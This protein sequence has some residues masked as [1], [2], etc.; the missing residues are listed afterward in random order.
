MNVIILTTRISGTDGVSLEA[1]RW[2]EILQS[3]GHKVTFV[4]GKLDRPG[5]LIPELHFQWPNVVELHDEV[6]W[7]KGDYKKVEAEIFTVAGVIEGKLREILNR[8][9]RVDLLIIANALSIP[10]H[11]PLAV[12]LTRV[13]EELK[14]PVIARHHDFWW[15][16]KRFLKSTMFP[17]FQR[18]FPPNLP[19]LHHVVI[20][21]IAKK[22]LY[23][24]YRINSHVIW[25][26]FDFKSRQLQ[27]LDSFNKNWRSDF[28]IKDDDIVFLQATRIVPRK[29]IELAI[30]LVE[31]LGNKSAV[32]VIAGY[33]GD[34]GKEY[35]DYLRKIVRK[36]VV[37]VR[38]IGNHINSQRKMKT[39]KVYTLWDCFVHCDFVTY[40]TKVEGFG[41]QF[42][43]TI[44]FKKP[45]ILTPYSVFKSDIEPLGFETILMPDKV[46]KNVISE[47]NSLIEDK[48]RRRKMVEKNF[49]L[50]KKHFSYEATAKKL[51]KIFKEMNLE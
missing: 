9:K 28:K 39:Q 33:S 45:I 47:V 12:A 40:P 15:E 35:E 38:F 21:S 6:I 29:R 43:E 42:I 36:K 3:M 44:Y 25:D 16:R 4:A 20:N 17:F 18:W 31:K 14:I 1:V 10:M 30:E 11:F 51:Q 19:H 23:K 32:L 46:T 34:E 50:G 27:K 48:K 41:N 37:R 24:R 5:I 8:G 26:T 13:I 7:G 22:E 49:R 2:R